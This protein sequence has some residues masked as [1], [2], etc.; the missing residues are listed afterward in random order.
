MDKAKNLITETIREELKTTLPKMLRKIIREEI[1]S[2]VKQAVINNLSQRENINTVNYLTPQH[3]QQPKSP[4]KTIG[5]P[6]A[7]PILDMMLQ[8]TAHDLRAGKTPPIGP[9]R[10]GGMGGTTIV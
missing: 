9:D 3:I 10:S 1:E 8:E 5:S 4:Q 2:L 6:R 7:N